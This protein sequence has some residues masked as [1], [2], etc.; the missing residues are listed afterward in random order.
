MR[1]ASTLSTTPGGAP[2]RTRRSPREALL[3]ARADERRARREERH[4]LALHVGAHERAV[5][6]VV[7]EERHERGGDAHHLVGRDV[8]QLDHGR[9]DD[10]EVAVEARGHEALRTCSV[11]EAGRRLR[12][13]LA[14]L[15]E[16]AEPLH[17]VGDLASPT[18]RYGVSTKPY[19]LTRA[20]VES[21]AMRPMFGPSGVSIGQ[22]RP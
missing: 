8:H 7:L 20:N 14:L 16:R 2:R 4:G 9:R 3:H 1:V 18:L 22:M 15:F 5:R 17:L 13:V 12:D 10:L 21:D 6:V 11:V 19:S